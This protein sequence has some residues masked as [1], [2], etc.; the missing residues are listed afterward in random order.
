MSDEIRYSLRSHV[1]AFRIPPVHDALVIGQDSPIGCQALQR[2]LELI[3]AQPFEHMAIG[4]EVVSDLMVR[5]A[6]LKRL[7]P[8][9]LRNYVIGRIKP[10]MGPEEI[11]HLDLFPEIV[12]ESAI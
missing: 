2:A 4:D 3:V 6:L 11:L 9:R 10:L 5:K 7:P 12:M 1:K 8:D